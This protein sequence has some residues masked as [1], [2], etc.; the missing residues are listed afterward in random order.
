[1]KY[2]YET[3]MHTSEVS[4]CAVSTAA[5]QV[6]AYKSRGYAGIIVTDHFINGW[7][8]CP[9]HLPWK[10]KMN[11]IASG[12]KKAKIEGDKCGL[13]VFFGWEFTVR[14]SDFLT[15]GL[16]LDFLLAHPNLD[17][18]SVEDYSGLVRSYGGFLVQAHP[19]RKAGHIEYQFPVEHWLVDAIEV[20][21]ASMPEETNA[22]ALN[23]AKHHNLP[24]LAGTDSHGNR[25]PFYSGIK[26]NKKAESIFDI[27]EAIETSTAALILP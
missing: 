5:E 13:D 17:I 6:R 10:D 26:L 19:F 2:L 15:F 27:I 11:Y 12:Y 20:Y 23:F 18:F 9:T 16:D 24:M 4:G 3:H 7:T 1:M 25:L 14:G 8:T 21:N 22:K